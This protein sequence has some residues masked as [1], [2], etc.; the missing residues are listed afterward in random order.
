[1]KPNDFPKKTILDGTEELYTQTSG[2][3]EKF[4]LEQAKDYIRPYKVYTALLTQSGTDA[5][6]ATVL[7]NTLGFDIQWQRLQS[8]FYY[9]HIYDT[10]ETS[11]S[12]CFIGGFKQQNDIP[13]TITDVSVF[14]R[15]DEDSDLPNGTNVIIWLKTISALY[16]EGNVSLNYNFIDDST[17]LILNNTPIEIRVYN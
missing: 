6:V 4:S 15:R 7:E 12:N 9:A 8:G 10:D 17:F 1:M 11:K 16:N 13:S 14:L 2:V 5:P 3:S